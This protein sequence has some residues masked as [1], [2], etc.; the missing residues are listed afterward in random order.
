MA[1]KQRDEFLIGV[2]RTVAERAAYICSNPECRDSTIEPHSDP[3]KSLKTGEAAHIRAASP[4]GPRYDATQ[5]PEER[6]SIQNAIWLC[7]K[8]ST[9]ID[10]DESRY[11]VV[12]LLGWK[13][14]HEDWLRNGGVVPPPPN[15][16]IKTLDGFTLPETPGTIALKECQDLR[17]H[18]LRVWNSS[19]TPVLMIAAR[20]QMPEP[21]VARWSRERPPGVAA[22]F[23]PD[24]EDIVASGTGEVTRNRPPLP[25]KVFRLRIDR[26]PPTHA[27][28]I[29]MYTS[30]K[31]YQDHDLTFD[32]GPF[33]ELAKGDYLLQFIDGTFQFEYRGATITKKFFA[34]IAYDKATRAMSVVEV[35]ENKGDW[36]PVELTLI[37]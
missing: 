34:P 14:T 20:L 4:G 11:P 24:R 30:M 25:S 37:S 10:K 22:E 26:L 5:T 16:S 6:S 1:G 2:Q 27:V 21:I 13:Q 35:R 9:I 36:K 29:A 18:R 28:E 8:C 15:F 23:N 17:E 12:L 7:T 31:V 19:V 32:S 3:E 33:A